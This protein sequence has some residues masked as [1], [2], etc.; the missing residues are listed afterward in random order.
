MIVTLPIYRT[1]GPAHILR[2]T[3]VIA[4]FSAAF[5]IKVHLGMLRNCSVANEYFTSRETILSRIDEATARQDS[6]AL[7]WLR[8]RYG[9]CVSDRALQTSLRRG[10]AK[11]AARD[12]ELQ[13]AISRHLDLARS[14]EKFAEGPQLSARLSQAGYLV[15]LR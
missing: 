12:A 1:R 10:L 15:P 7:T 6:R 14:S 13:L 4:L 3:I 11:I 2:L 5:L 9:S 8:D